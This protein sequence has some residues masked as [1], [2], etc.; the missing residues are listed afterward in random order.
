MERGGFQ[1]K[2]CNR[3]NFNLNKYKDIKDSVY[4]M[5]KNCC[6]FDCFYMFNKK[7]MRLYRGLVY[8]LDFYLCFCIDFYNFFFLGLYFFIYEN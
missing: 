8:Y 1:V 3:V 5:E 6:M 4:V 2:I 7:M